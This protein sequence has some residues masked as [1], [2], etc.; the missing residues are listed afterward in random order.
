MRYFFVMFR[1]CSVNSCLRRDTDAAYVD[2]LH[3][4]SD[5]ISGSSVAI[6]RY[7]DAKFPKPMVLSNWNTFPKPMLPVVVSA[8]MLQHKSL[9]WHLE[10]MV[11]WGED[12]AARG[13]RSKG[14]PVMGSAR[15]EIYNSTGFHRQTLGFR[16]G[17]LV[18]G[19][20]D[21]GI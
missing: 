19:M 9:V 17:P 3:Y 14:D 15:M 4:G 13:G 2:L 11:R 8:T 20:I 7:L 10:M 21:R 1:K 16:I 6:L 18:V 12:L 5:V